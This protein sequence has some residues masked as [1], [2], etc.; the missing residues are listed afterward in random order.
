MTHKKTRRFVVEVDSEIGLK[1]KYLT[2]KRGNKIKEILEKAIL[3]Y[4]RE[5]EKDEIKQ[6]C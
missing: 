6:L 4:V 3:D 1:F 5:A 2:A